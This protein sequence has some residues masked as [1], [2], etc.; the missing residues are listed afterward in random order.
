MRVLNYNVQTHL[1][2]LKASMIG[3]FVFVKAIVT[4]VSSVRPFMESMEHECQ[5]CG[6]IFAEGK[7]S[8][9]YKAPQ[10][11]QTSGCNSR[12]FI[13]KIYSAGTDIKNF[14]SLRLSTTLIPLH[15]LQENFDDRNDGRSHQSIECYLFD[16]LVD[17]V[18]PGDVIR[19]SGMIKVDSLAGTNAFVAYS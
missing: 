12:I 7:L 2:E 14:Q 6:K 16:N 8:G 1:T 4:R 9:E 19:V 3:Q 11:C 13:P 5:R 18:N 15:R 10:K 17:K